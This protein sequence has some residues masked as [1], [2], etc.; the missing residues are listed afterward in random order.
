MTITFA[1][2]FISAYFTEGKEMY[3]NINSIGEANVEFGMLIFF[4]IAILLTCIFIWGLLFPRVQKKVVSETTE[5]LI[6][7]AGKKLF[8]NL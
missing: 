8:Q 1:I 3:W 5:Q 2:S 6:K 7:K 4:I